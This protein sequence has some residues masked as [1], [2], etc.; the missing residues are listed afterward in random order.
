MTGHLGRLKFGAFRGE[1]GWVRYLGS[2]VPLAPLAT[3]NAAHKHQDNQDTTP[4][5]PAL[6]RGATCPP[7]IGLGFSS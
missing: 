4:P 3:T 5:T 2:L 6:L 1:G 7:S